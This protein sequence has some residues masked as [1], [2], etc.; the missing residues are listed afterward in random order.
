[1]LN[2]HVADLVEE[3]GAA[4]RRLE[5]APPLPDRKRVSIDRLAMGTLEK[6]VLR[7]GDAFWRRP[8]RTNLVYLSQEPG[9]FPFF[10]DLTPY[11]GEPILACLYCG[12]FADRAAA[13]SDNELID[14]AAAVV[15]EISG[16]TGR[17]PTDGRVTRWRADPFALGAYSYLPVGSSGADL[18]N[19]AEPVGS[20]LLFAGE[21]T[22]AIYSGYVHGGI[23]SGAREA[24][25]L[26]GG[27]PVLESGV[28][29]SAGCGM[30]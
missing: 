21:A 12:D 19:L 25:R 1:L 20:R 5:F 8:G 6:V 16:V 29:A 11:T 22:S 10:A 7:F 14:R 3:E 26:I 27:P 2:G 4:V 24:A 18:E 17:Q 15:G 13:M 28:I 23:V 9:E 30:T